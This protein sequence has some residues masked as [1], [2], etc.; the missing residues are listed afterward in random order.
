[1]YLRVLPLEVCYRNKNIYG[2]GEK[3]EIQKYK[4]IRLLFLLLSAMSCLFI[5]LVSLPQPLSKLNLA[6]AVAIILQV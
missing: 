1:L 4:K 3:R 5:S 6:P 2:I